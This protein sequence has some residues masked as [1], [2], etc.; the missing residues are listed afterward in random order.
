MIASKKTKA[1][2]L[3]LQRIG[4]DSGKCGNTAPVHLDR[5]GE[6]ELARGRVHDLERHVVDGSRDGEELKPGGCGLDR[7]LCHDGLEA[8]LLEPRHGG[9]IGLLRGCCEDEICDMVEGNRVVLLILHCR[10]KCGNVRG[11]KVS[12][13]EG[14]NE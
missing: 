14:R 11:W 5:G 3:Y 9:M 13:E 12:E 2:C 10:R 8:E 6:L 1:L 4:S 7:G